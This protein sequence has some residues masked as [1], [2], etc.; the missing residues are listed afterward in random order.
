MSVFWHEYAPCSHEGFIASLLKLQDHFMILS[1]L[2]RQKSLIIFKY[3]NN[4]CYTW[5]PRQKISHQMMNNQMVLTS[6]QVKQPRKR[7][8]IMVLLSRFSLSLFV[9]TAAATHSYPSWKN[10]PLKP[11]EARW[12]AEKSTK[13]DNP[14]L[15]PGRINQDIWVSTEK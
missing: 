12:I 15:L 11:L 3:S 1:E 2:F 10:V 9:G 5:T 7:F 8:Y 4:T 13:L 14:E 6:H